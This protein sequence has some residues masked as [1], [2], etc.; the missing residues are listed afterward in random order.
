M[1]EME[2]FDDGAFTVYQTRWKTYASRD[3]EG[4]GLCS[5]LDKSAV[6]FWS[7][8]HLNGFANSYATHTGIS[9]E[10]GDLLK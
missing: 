10:V 4:T 2:V 7:R 8:E 1:T 5:G 9:T 6:I 3:K